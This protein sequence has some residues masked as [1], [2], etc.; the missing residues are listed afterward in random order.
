MEPWPANTLGLD[1][2]AAARALGPAPA[3]MID[4]HT[5]IHGREAAKIYARVRELYG[6][7]R[8]YTMTQISMAAEVREVLGESVRFITMPWFRGND[9]EHQHRGG[10]LEVIERFHGEFG[11]RMMKLWAAPALREFLPSG[12]VDVADIDSAWRRE[13]ARLAVSLGMM[14]MVHVADP[15]TWFAARY[16]HGA[17]FGTK[18]HQY[19]GLRRMLDEFPVPWIAAH[20]GGWS[21][22]LGFLDRL[23][24]AHP[25]LHLDTSATKWV[26]R[27]LSG[28]EPS[29]VRDF[30]TRH[31]GRILFGTDLVTMDD[32]LSLA[33]TGMSRMAD[34]ASSPEQAF[35]LYCSRHWTLRTLFETGYDGPSAIADPDLAMIDPARYTAMSAPRLRGCALPADVLRALYHD[36][37]ANLVDRWWAEHA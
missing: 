17:T 34:L 18:A 25:N 15:D 7:E 35:E 30:F 6:V 3:R 1:Y 36:T 22:D 8:T 31:K 28:H 20:M 11:A 26:V 37:A 21:E 27:G 4:V 29:E 33:K 14:I 5:H 10:Y 32:Q 2:V 12:A 13:H 16:H 23:L 9:P 24:T 19:V